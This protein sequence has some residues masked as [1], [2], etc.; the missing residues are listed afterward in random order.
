MKNC[1]HE[2]SCIY[3]KLTQ[4]DGLPCYYCHCEKC[5]KHFIIWLDEGKNED[6]TCCICG[7]TGKFSKDKTF[8]IC[9]KCYNN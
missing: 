6:M 1:T 7:N 4:I 5:E 9:D 3:D 8:E 2:D